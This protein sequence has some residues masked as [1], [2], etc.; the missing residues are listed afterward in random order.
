MAIIDNR[1]A[2]SGFETGDTPAQPDDLSGAAG[3]TADA[4]IFIEGSRSWGYYTTSS[5]A[6]LLYDAGS[7]QNWANNTFYLWVN[8]GIAGLLDTKANGGLAVRFCG[9]T[10]TNWFEVN[11]AGSDDYPTAQKGGWVC[12]VVDVEKAKAASNRTGGT[13]PATTA[14]RYVGVTTITGGTMPRMADNTWLDKIW[15]LPQNTPGIRVEGQNTG[16]VDW[17]WADLLSWSDTNAAG[18]VNPAAGGAIAI[19]APIRFGAND[20]V[21]HG[22]SDTNAVVLWENWDVAASFYGLE[23]IGGSGAQSFQLGVKSGTGDD[24]TGSQGGVIAAA[25]SGQRWFFDCDDANIDA[26]N[27]YGASL[28]HTGDMQLDNVNTSFISNVIVD[29]TSA[30]LTGI[31]DFLRCQVVDPNTADGVAWGV[32]D[33]LSDIVH[34]TF[35]FSDGHALELTTPRVANQTSK[36]NRF[37]GYGATATNDA[38]LYN[39]AGGAV[40]I[41]A[42]DG[43]SVSEHTYRNGTSATTTVTASISITFDAGVTGAEY[44]IYRVSD[45]GEEDGT[46]SA[47]GTT[48]AAALQSGVSYNVWVFKE[49]YVPYYRPGV[50]YTASVTIGVNL[51]ADGNYLDA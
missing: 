3:G 36:G 4:E 47:A 30:T 27:V 22:F 24:A 14:I 37:L 29:G 23:V 35:S 6:G 19:N 49:G 31:G 7:A 9:A 15:R 17:T 43:A 46:E 5:R 39:N 41:A 8:C 38:A 13:P 11:V 44:R 20:A 12:L 32:T 42:T 16:S 50:T 33:D 18:M 34:S 25:S 40:A 26:C 10:V 48:F 1:T 45:G 2:L 51:Q 28:I 21:T